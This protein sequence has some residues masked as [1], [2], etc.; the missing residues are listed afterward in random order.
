[1]SASI[2]D[3]PRGRRLCLE[4]ARALDE[5]ISRETL[6]LAFELDPGRSTSRV[7]F[8]MAGTGPE[9][10]EPEPT[11]SVPSLVALLGEI[12]A[13][14][15]DGATVQE[16]LSYS[17]DSA[18]YWQEPDGE[19]VL[20]ALPEV[21]AALAPIAAALDDRPD[22][23]WWHADRREAQWAIDWR[24]QADRAPLAGD[25]AAELA[26]WADAARADEIRS[27][28]ERPSDP[29]AMVGGI[30]WSAPT[31]LPSTTGELPDGRPAGLL[32]VEDALGWET[33]TAIPV[34]GAGRT[35]EIRGPEDWAELCRRHPLEVTASRR[36]EWYRTTGRVRRWVMPD[37]QSVA[38]EWDAVHLTTVGYLTAATRDI[39]VDGEASSVI[40]GWSP[41]ATYWL[42]DVVHEVDG[43][44]TFSRRT[45][46]DEW[47]R[48]D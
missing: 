16:A 13:S 27:E 30:W 5:R 41:D 25:P 22:L 19:D 28:R 2:A 46:G 20:A 9:E 24:D 34:S 4:L 33:A 35:Y 15:A 40:A 31:T 8:A 26:R 44:R 10:R 6:G 39:A 23:A 7:V 45:P 47:V 37:W 48:A 17:V 36:H 1:M 29:A 21:R 38:T 43:Q 18:R 3:G 32:L 42:S 11:G 12:D 14:A